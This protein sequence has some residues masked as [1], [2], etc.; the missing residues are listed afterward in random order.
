M[1][2]SNAQGGLGHSLMDSHEIIMAYIG[3]VDVYSLVLVTCNSV[4][5]ICIMSIF[6]AD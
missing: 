6:K 3:A 1:I 5:R 4:L 2:V